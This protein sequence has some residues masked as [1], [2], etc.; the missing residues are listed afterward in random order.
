M[1]MELMDVTLR[2][3][4]YLPNNKITIEAAQNL[5]RGLSEAGVDYIQKA[6]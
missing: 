2:E 5:V 6:V 1:K 3:S 4:I